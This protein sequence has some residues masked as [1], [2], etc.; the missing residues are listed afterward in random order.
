MF[1]Q[2]NNNGEHPF[3][4]A[5]RE[6]GKNIEKFL[7]FIEKECCES[8]ITDQLASSSKTGETILHLVSKVKKN[9]AVI[10]VVI[11]FM[12]KHLTLDK[13]KY[14]LLFKTQQNKNFLNSVL[15]HQSEKDIAKIFN[16]VET[17]IGATVLSD[18]IY[19]KSNNGYPGLFSAFE[20]VSVTNVTFTVDFIRRN[21]IQHDVKNQ[22]LHKTHVK[23]NILNICLGNAGTLLSLLDLLRS[24]LDTNSL[25]SLFLAP[26]KSELNLIISKMFCENEI[27]SEFLKDVF[28]S[29]ARQIILEG[30]TTLGCCSAS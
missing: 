27:F 4:T 10:C 8:A 16:L 9:G 22:I 13:F 2:K 30:K 21:F 29:N 26:S 24:E 28:T 17:E 3:S 14:I 12:K 25:E 1:L 18:L 5:M 19:D 11:L 6:N 23:K 15:Q 20:S 7:S